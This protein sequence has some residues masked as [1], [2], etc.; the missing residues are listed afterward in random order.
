MTPNEFSLKQSQ[1]CHD[2]NLNTLSLSKYFHDSIDY[3]KH[4]ALK[5]RVKPRQALASVNIK[6]MEQRPKTSVYKPNVSYALRS[7]SNNCE[8]MNLDEYYEKAL[9]A[10]T[11]DELISGI[12]PSGTGKDAFRPSTVRRRNR[13]GIEDTNKKSTSSI[14]PRD[15]PSQNKTVTF[16]K[17]S[18]QAFNDKRIV[19]NLIKTPQLDTINIQI[20]RNKTDMSVTSLRAPSLKHLTDNEIVHFSERLHPID[21]DI[22]NTTPRN[23][24]HTPKSRISSLNS[25]NVMKKTRS[26]SSSL[27]F[28]YPPKSAVNSRPPS[29]Q[30]HN[31][32]QMLNIQKNVYD[33]AKSKNPNMIVNNLNEEEFIELL[34]E[35]RRTKSINLDCILTLKSTVKSK[36]TSK[37]STP[38]VESSSNGIDDKNSTQHIIKSYTSF[39]TAGMAPM[40]LNDDI[41]K[42]PQSFTLRLPSQSNLSFDSNAN[43]SLFQANQINKLVGDAQ[44][45]NIHFTNNNNIFSSTTTT[46][47]TTTPNNIINGKRLPSAFANYLNNKILMK[48]SKN[49]VGILIK[50]NE[51]GSGD[52]KETSNGRRLSSLYSQENLQPNEGNQNFQRIKILNFP[53]FAN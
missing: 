33:E 46:T 23:T 4:S 41:A 32:K 5:I 40:N 19:N 49:L 48:N 22:S 45:N 14:S 8:D 35:Y 9:S 47:T 25:D 17:N 2:Q 7:S 11:K 50:N 42:T 44:V 6:L 26:G 34:K 36:E 28:T 1:T 3:R 18:T 37:V 10:M 29:M 24:P 53:A 16:D 21:N 31:D 38:N 30:M 13:S 12:E 51:K 52:G 20:R 27:R 43:S 15:R 39:N